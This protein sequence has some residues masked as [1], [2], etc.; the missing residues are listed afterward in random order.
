MYL[1]GST[2]RSV[3]LVRFFVFSAREDPESALPSCSSCSLINGP[4]SVSLLACLLPCL[5]VV[6]YPSGDAFPLDIREETFGMLRRRGRPLHCLLQ[7]GWIV[8]ASPLSLANV[9]IHRTGR[10]RLFG[11]RE[12]GSA[13]LSSG[14]Q[15]FMRALSAQL[16]SCFFSYPARYTSGY[17]IRRPLRRESSSNTCS[18][19]PKVVL[20]LRGFRGAKP[21]QLPPTPG[22]SLARSVVAEGLD[23]AEERMREIPRWGAERW[24]RLQ[25]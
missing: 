8:R 13:H 17:G 18:A 9:P 23:G 24:S 14:H 4:Y 21:R 22:L 2:C 10:V 12:D 25:G 16:R 19:G 15:R 6:E 3:C 7:S 1:N 5:L 11:C 20:S